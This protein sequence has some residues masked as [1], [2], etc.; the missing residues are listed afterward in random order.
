MPLMSSTCETSHEERSWLKSEAPWNITFMSVTR[1]TS[2][3]ETFPLK[4]VAIWNMPLMS[5]TC[6][7]SHE[8]RGWLKAEAPLNMSP[9]SVTAE[10]SHEERFPLKARRFVEHGAHVSHLRDV[11][12]G[13][14]LVEVGGAPEHVEPMSVTCETFHEE[15]A[16]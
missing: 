9:M 15:R 11:P 2:H 16:G 13:E 1:E 8:E 6:E 10:A 7:T 12:R 4:E 3:E 5:S 14:G